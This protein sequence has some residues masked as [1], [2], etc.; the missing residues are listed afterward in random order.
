MTTTTPMCLPCY[1]G[2]TIMKKTNFNQ[3]SWTHIEW[4]QLVDTILNVISNSCK[5]F[6]L[7][8]DIFENAASNLLDVYFTTLQLV[9]VPVVAVERLPVHHHSADDVLFSLGS[10]GSLQYI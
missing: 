5:I 9:L 2:N 3:S 7:T 10:L 4:L 8:T 1:A 6:D